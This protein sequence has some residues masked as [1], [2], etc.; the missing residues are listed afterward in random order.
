MKKKIVK[1]NEYSLVEIMNYKELF[2]YDENEVIKKYILLINEYIKFILEKTKIKNS[3]F[4]R[5]IIIRGCYTVTNVFNNILYYT[6]NLD[7][8]F[9]HC[10]KAY[11]Y[12]IEFIEQITDEQHIFLQLT[13]RDASVYVYKKIF[14]DLSCNINNPI[15]S[16]SDTDTD[17]DNLKKK[18]VF[19]DEHIKIFNIIFGFIIE[20][21][22]L[23][24]DNLN[25][26]KNNYFKTICE[27]INTLNLE[28]EHCK[29]IYNLI[30]KTNK[31]LENHDDVLI[32][33]NKLLINILNKYAKYKNNIHLFISKV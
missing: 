19:I 30:E 12:Y 7:L 6:K 17:T 20:N 24:E 22:N 3:K 8:T 31:S 2:N 14:S 11:Y 26:I 4:L 16:I 13:S 32:E 5:F 33:Y 28:L 1:E 29:V 27:K 25:I 18:L 15:I 23:N 21:L 9:Y 10:Q